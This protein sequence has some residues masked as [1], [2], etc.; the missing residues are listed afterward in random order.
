MNAGVDGLGRELDPLGRERSADLGQLDGVFDR[1]D[2]SLGRQV[3]GRGEAPGAVVHDA[4]AD[5][6][7]LA[8]IGALKVAVAEPDELAAQ[9]LHPYVGMLG[10]QLAGASQCRVRESVEGQREEVLVD[11]V[12]GR[13]SAP[14]VWSGGRVGSSTSLPVERRESSSSWAR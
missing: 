3:G 10:A 7:V 4:D 8:V 1:S 5:A 11:D 14:E 12:G 2:G 13:H 9:A 6:E